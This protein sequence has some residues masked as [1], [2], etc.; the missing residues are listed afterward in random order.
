MAVL[1]LSC[2]MRD[3][4]P[5]PGIECGSP[6]WG[7]QSLSHWATRKV[8]IRNF[9]GFSFNT[10]T[11]SKNLRLNNSPKCL[12]VLWSQLLVSLSIISSSVCGFLNASWTYYGCSHLRTFVWAVPSSWTFFFFIPN[13]C[14][15]S[16]TSFRF[17]VRCHLIRPIL[18]TLFNCQFVFPWLSSSL[19]I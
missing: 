6:A 14:L 8:P 12:S 19:L 9:V 17:L 1:S 15:I 18:I 16:V 4:V 2:S 11:Q 7:P 10:I 3:L 5:W 13:K